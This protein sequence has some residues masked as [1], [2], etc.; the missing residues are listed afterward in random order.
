MA[1]TKEQ[2][3]ILEKQERYLTDMATLRKETMLKFQ[4]R[5]WAVTLTPDGERANKMDVALSY[6]KVRASRGELFAFVKAT[7]SLAATYSST[8]TALPR[9]SR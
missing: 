1:E 8:T 5:T 9:A 7:R 4:L 6:A 3:F 2:R